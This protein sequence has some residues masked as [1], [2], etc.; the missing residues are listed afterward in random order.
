MNTELTQRIRSILAANSNVEEKP[1]FGGV[2]FMLN[3]NMAVAARRDS[4]LLARIGAKEADRTV[5]EP[6]VERMVMRGR[7]MKDYVI[8]AADRLNDAALQ[9][10]IGLAFAFVG[11]LPAKA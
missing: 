10:W 7:K 9:K 2:C 8:V 6:G 4:S 5:A 1:M 3:G 11:A